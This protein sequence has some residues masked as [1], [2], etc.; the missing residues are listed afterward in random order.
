MACLLLMAVASGCDGSPSRPSTEAVATIRVVNETFRVLLTSAEQVAAAKAAQAGGRA[1]I[2]LGR[3]VPGTQANAGY[4]WH[5]EDVSF[6]ETAIELCDGT[7][8]MVEQAGGQWG[9]GYFCPWGAS[10]VAV[11]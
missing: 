8:S 9:N 3:I 2:P 10:V 11:Q 7:P 5:L 6:V 1:R 4:S